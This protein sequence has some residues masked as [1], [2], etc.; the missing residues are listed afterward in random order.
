MGPAPVRRLRPGQG[1][2][3][4]PHQ[5]DREPFQVHNATVGRAN[6]GCVVPWYTSELVYGSASYP[7]LASHVQRAQASGLPGATFANPLT[8]TE[9]DTIINT[10]RQTACGDAPSI[11]GLSWDEYPIARSREG[12][13]SGGARRTFDGC[14]TANVF[15]GTGPI[16]FSVCMITATE[17]N[18]QG[19]LNTQFFRAERV[20]DGD[21]F[22][23]TV[24]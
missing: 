20:L 5:E 2:A 10:N 8:R 15:S 4:R 19:G 6:V 12:L 18:A 9:D 3:L 1:P 24:S 13:S 21:P 11:T 22:R 17:N 16:G 23:V 14:Q 7:S